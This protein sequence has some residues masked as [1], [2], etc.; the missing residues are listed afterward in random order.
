MA[1]YTVRTDDNGS[2]MEECIA[3]CVWPASRIQG[4]IPLYM[5]LRI[6]SLPKPRY[7]NLEV[8]QF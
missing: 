4:G 7:L 6:I 2:G 5:S 8:F 3:I 1:P